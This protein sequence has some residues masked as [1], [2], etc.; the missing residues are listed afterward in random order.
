MIKTGDVKCDPAK[1]KSGTGTNRRN[2]KCQTS[3]VIP[4]SRKAGPAQNAGTSNVKWDPNKQKTKPQRRKVRQSHS[5]HAE[6]GSAST[7][8]HLNLN[9]ARKGE[10]HKIPP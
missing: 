9:F 6:L 7:L 4:L 10:F 5:C 3:N 2:V 8:K 1:Q